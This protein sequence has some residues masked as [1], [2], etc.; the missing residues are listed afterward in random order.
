MHQL[1][2]RAAQQV[3]AVAV[4]IRCCCTGRIAGT[5]GGTPSLR[6]NAAALSCSP[7]ISVPSYGSCTALDFHPRLPTPLLCTATLF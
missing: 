1:G 7:M 6:H 2:V 3:G 5:T 4:L